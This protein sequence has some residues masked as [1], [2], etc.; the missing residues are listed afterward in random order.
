MPGCAAIRIAA[1]IGG[2]VLAALPLAAGL[3]PAQAKADSVFSE[4]R[5]GLLAHDVPILSTQKEHGQDI[6]GEL[7]FT[8]P[9]SDS[10]ASNAG[11]DWRWLLQPRPTIGGSANTSG[12][13]SQ[14][15]LGMTWTVPLASHVVGATDGVFLGFSFGPSFN[16]G[17]VS[18]GVDD[19]KALGSNVLFRES[20]ELGYMVT[21][22][23]S[24]SVM[25]DHESN[26]G[27]ANHNDG[28]DSLG[29][30]LG[31]KF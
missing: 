26:A 25:F 1:R 15:Y 20:L 5:L 24:V 16:N 21:S 14:A 3:L 29:V 10:F 7:L 31:L 30:R 8:T 27:I 23:V 18:S 17:H 6:N 11:P 9:F 28:L 13:T 2:L 12:F 4:V 22:R 19:R